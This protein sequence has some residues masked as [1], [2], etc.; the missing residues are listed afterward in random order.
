PRLPRRGRGQGSLG[1]PD[2]PVGLHARLRAVSGRERAMRHRI[3]LLCLPAALALAAAASFSPSAHAADSFKGTF[4]AVAAADAVRVTWVVPHAP[5]SDTVLDVGGPSAQATLDSIGGSQAYAS[6]PYPGENTVTAPALIAGASGGKINLPAYPFWVGSSYPVAPKSEAG[7]G[8]YSIKAE[9][10]DSAS[11]SSASVGLAPSGGGAAG[12][13]RSTAST[14]T[15]PDTVTSEAAT[16]IT[17]FTA[18][19]LKIGQVLSRAKTVFSG[20]GTLTRDADTQV[21]GMMVGD[22]PVALTAKG[23]VVGSS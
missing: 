1:R 13:A 20:A 5:A 21:T 7:N 11:T 22:T 9:S 17:A 12:L 15:T 10:S 14:A 16:E 3:G 8:P 18:G 2:Q 4:G 6:F 19:P 23:L